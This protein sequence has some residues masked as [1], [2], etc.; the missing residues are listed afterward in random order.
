MDRI[1]DFNEV[2]NRVKDEE[3]DKFESYI[4]SLYYKMMEGQMSMADFSDEMKA[5]AIENNISEDKFFKLQTKMMERYGVDSKFIEEQL[6]RAGIN[7]SVQGNP[8]NYEAT[9]RAMSFHEKY[10]SRIQT[11]MFTT[12][13]IKNIKNDIKILIDGVDVIL[14][15]HGEVDLT[16][17]EL[18][19]FLCSYKKLN[20][21]KEL[22]I[23][24]YNNAKEY[25]Y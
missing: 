2:K 14:S 4:Y 17:T 6:K 12:Y 16:D 5:Y 11:K 22:N 23:S 19:E 18:N 24:I 13:Y 20:D 1:I 10:K 25:Q 21:D 15:S 3:V 9:R 7:P 8:I